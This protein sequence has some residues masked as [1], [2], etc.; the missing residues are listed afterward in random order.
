[1]SKEYFPEKKVANHRIYAYTINDVESHEGAI[2]IGESMRDPHIRIKEQT[3]TVGVSYNLLL[4]KS[5]IRNDGSVI[6]DYAVRKQLLSKGHKQSSVGREWIECDIED[7]ESSINEL[8]LNKTFETPRNLNFKMRP[9]QENAVNLTSQFI[10][11]FNNEHPGKIPKFLWNA[12]MRFGKT[13]TTYQLAK[14]MDFQKVLV[15]TFKPAVENS[16]REDL[17]MHVDFD[18]W[19]FYSKNS[20]IDYEDLNK[21][22]NLVCFGSFQDFLGKNPSTGGI[23]TKNEWVHQTKWDL[24]VFD[25]YH[26]GAW[27][28]N[29]KE[30]FESDEVAEKRFLMGDGIDYFDEEVLPITSKSY[31][32]LSGTPFKAISSGEFLEDQIFN[33]TY[34]DEQKGKKEWPN[35]EESNPYK[36]LPRMVMMTYQLPDSMKEIA[37][38]GEF[39]QFS[40]NRFFE[41]TGDA[42]NAKFIYED[43][44]QKWLDLIRGS[45]KN[46]ILQ[47]LKQKK[48]PPMPFSHAPLLRSLNHTVWVMPSVAA[49]FAMKKLLENRNNIFYHDYEVI[50]AAG[51]SAG[52]GLEA[53]P[54]VRKAMEDPLNSKTITLTFVKLLTGVTVRPWTGIFMLRSLESP[55][56]Y[57]QAAFRVQNAW[58]APDL[59]KEDKEIILKEECYI[60][61]FDPNR[62]LRKVV[63]YSSRL[64]D[65]EK[66][67]ESKVREF[68]KFLPVL[69]Y[70]GSFMQEIDAEGLIDMAMSG[71]TASLLARGWQSSLL[72]NVDDFTL[73]SLLNNKEAMDVLTKIEDFRNLSDDLEIIINKSEAVKKTKR[74]LNDSDLPKEERK[75]LTDDE[76]EVKSKRNQIKEKLQKFA[77]RIPI[78]MYLTDFRERALEDVITN[79]EPLLFK[80]VT[81]LTQ[82]DFKLLK[83]CGVFNEPLMN[84]MVFKFKRYEDSSLEYTGINNQQNDSVGLFSTTIS[85]KEYKKLLGE[86]K[87]IENI[88]E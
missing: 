47:N 73:N 58:T 20:L 33:W 80:K 27:R 71:T 6:R 2:K 46:E 17:E 15:M 11:N 85:T 3:Q 40:L 34:L 76:K 75:K 57:F 31:L 25:E 39:N 67:T 84:D 7:V 62:A 16:W 56:T 55:E 54:P 86:D 59:D 12:K 28:E 88:E 81:G 45:S 26:Y 72:V 24:V 49:C 4:N 19:Q 48:Q 29:A 65:G 78:F 82:G 69:A 77:T 66:S 79:L 52:I 37:E 83:N 13:F 50:C 36:S 35:S 5:A 63:E 53:L 74:E 70:D 22:K 18:D 42:S 1:M 9:E 32:Y 43:E 14:K 44:V 38:Q 30:L 68:L 87:I 8:L 21:D 23:K 41:A 64:V 51:S 61:D 10:T 60:F